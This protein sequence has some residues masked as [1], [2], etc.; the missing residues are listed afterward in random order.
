[1]IL[2]VIGAARVILF[3]T[4]HIAGA[5][6]GTQY[7]WLALAIGA[8]IIC[9]VLWGS[10]AGAMLP[11][12]LRFIKLDPAVCSAPFVATLVDVTGIVIFFNVAAFVMHGRGL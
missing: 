4:F 10:L 3:Q 7:P 12:F 8:S 1:L 5:D 2:A 9:V 11:I 6:Y